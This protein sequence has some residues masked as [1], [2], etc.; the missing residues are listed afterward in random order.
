MCTMFAEMKSV[1]MAKQ[2]DDSRA[3]SNPIYRV[4][5]ALL[6]KHHSS[7]LRRR[8]CPF[9]KT[10]SHVRLE[11]HLAE[12]E[13]REKPVPKKFREFTASPSSSSSSLCL[14]IYR[15]IFV[16]RIWLPA[17][18]RPSFFCFFGCLRG[19]RED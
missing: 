17:K 6:P 9:A 2:L 19:G 1:C 5:I 18:K 11:T 13:R 12:R 3:T 14:R 4:T 10:D 7:L 8:T 15:G 16:V